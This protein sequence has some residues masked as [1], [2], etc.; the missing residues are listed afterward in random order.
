MACCMNMDPRSGFSA[1][2]NGV[3]TTAAAP[4]IVFR[5]SAASRR[6]ASA[7]THARA[8]R[9]V[10]SDSLR[11]NFSLTFAFAARDLGLAFKLVCILKD[12]R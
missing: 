1:L 11:E 8:H 2:T 3:A 12:R 6:V 7:H 4:P 9:H 5:M 10:R